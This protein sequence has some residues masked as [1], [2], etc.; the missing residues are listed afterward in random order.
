MYF[1]ADEEH[2]GFDLYPM[3][4]SDRASGASDIY[5]GS[6]VEDV[7][8]V[9]MK[10]V[11]FRSIKKDEKDSEEVAHFVLFM[12]RDK[13]DFA[14]KSLQKMNGRIKTRR[15]VLLLRICKDTRTFR[16]VVE[17]DTYNIVVRM[18]QG[19]A[20]PYLFRKSG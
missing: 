19:C 16:S 15:D 12:S 2:P 1:K 18:L 7:G 9:R 11:E 4:K 10:E 14:N 6:F 17:D 5:I 13:H 20:P 8:K 3:R